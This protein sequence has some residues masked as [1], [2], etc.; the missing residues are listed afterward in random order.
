M[1]PQLLATPTAPPLQPPRA[2][3]RPVLSAQLSSGALPCAPPLLGSCKE[4]PH[5]HLKGRGEPAP[6][7]EPLL[8]AHST[9]VLCLPPPSAD[10]AHSCRSHQAVPVGLCPH[11]ASL[12]SF[13]VHPSPPPA[14][15]IMWHRPPGHQLRAR[16]YTVGTHWVERTEV[17]ARRGPEGKPAEEGG[18]AL[19]PELRPR[20][21]AALG[22]AGNGCRFLP[23]RRGSVSSCL[24]QQRPE[25]GAA[26]G[27]SFLLDPW[28]CVPPTP[29]TRTE[30]T[31]QGA[32]VQTRDAAGVRGAGPQEAGA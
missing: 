30:P 29:C 6:A 13:T 21:R 5:C 8:L 9:P 15:P 32:R 24:C 17:K 1:A 10:H 20:L 27:P 2:A 25:R 11:V 16:C 19:R 3:P 28:T 4:T 14:T 23:S 7:P 22:R 12:P 18:L 31:L 26:E